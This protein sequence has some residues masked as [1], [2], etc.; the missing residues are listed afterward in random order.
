MYRTQWNRQRHA[1]TNPRQ[2][3]AQS[4]QRIRRVPFES[5][6][7]TSFPNET[8]R[9]PYLFPRQRLATQ[10]SPS[11]FRQVEETRGS[12]TLTLMIIAQDVYMRVP[13]GSS[14]VGSLCLVY[15]QR[16]GP[17]G[18]IGAREEK[19]T[20]GGDGDGTGVGEG[21]RIRVPVRRHIQSGSEMDER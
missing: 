7:T 2:Y 17:M 16:Y 10:M 12:H 11:A 1:R 6:I 13:R 9:G 21:L 14:F 5:S 15:V 4:V 19:A 3:L 8:T 18:K 20:E